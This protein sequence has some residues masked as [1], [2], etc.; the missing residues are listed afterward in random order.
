MVDL[1]A[2]DYLQQER[3]SFIAEIDESA[4]RRLASSYHDG[5]EC[6]FFQPPKCG[7]FVVSYFVRFDNGDSWVVRVPIAPCLAFDAQEL[8]EREVVTMQLSA[9]IYPPYENM[10]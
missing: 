1:I 6:D 4:I 8:V 2:Q 5:D 9:P 10:V 7:R 3:D